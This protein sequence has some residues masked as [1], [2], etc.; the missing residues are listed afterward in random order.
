M[1]SGEI[2]SIFETIELYKSNQTELLVFAGESYGAGSSRDTATKA[3]W[4][5][6]VRA[7]IAESF[8]RIHRAKLINMGILPLLFADGISV[9][10]LELSASDVFDLTLDLE[11]KQ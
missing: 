4:L 8:E 2:V 3:P 7:V 10:D 11:T 5:G 9:F 1:P 6:G